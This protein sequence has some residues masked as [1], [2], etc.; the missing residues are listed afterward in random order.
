MGASAALDGRQ[1][2][3]NGSP[4]ILRSCG[5]HGCHGVTNVLPSGADHGDSW[6]PW[7]CLFTARVACAA[8]S[9]RAGEAPVVAPA[10]SPVAQRW[11]DWSVDGWLRW[12]DCQGHGGCSLMRPVALVTGM[13]GVVGAGALPLLTGS[14]E[15]VALTGRRFLE[16][17]CEQVAVDLRARRLGLDAGSF[18][19]LAKRADVIVHMAGNVDY[20]ACAQDLHA[21]NEGGAAE[22][23]ALADAA[24]CPLLY[25]STAFADRHAQA[26]REAGIGGLTP[27]RPS[28]YHRSKAA[29]D[30]RVRQCAQP[31][32]IIRPSIV[33][34]DSR[35]GSMPQRQTMH[36]TL[37]M[38]SSGLL[39][40]MFGHPDHLIDM[41]PRDY[42]AQA[43]HQLA[44]DAVEGRPLPREFWA[45]AGPASLTWAQ[46]SQVLQH[47]LAA[48][49]RP[50][51]PPLQLDP[52]TLDVSDYPGWD[53]LR[54]AHQRGMATLYVASLA[55]GPEAFPTSFAGGGP[56]RP[57]F[58]SALAHCLLAGDIA[59]LLRRSRPHAPTA[60]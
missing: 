12:R 30:E 31:W 32:S 37:S 38:M 59:W 25:V 41:V 52:F 21:V 44:L 56:G 2:R 5:D 11:W 34:G 7:A 60:R 47:T 33:M 4:C 26:S 28:F 50:I 18:A 15:V 27:A 40:A 22:M 20:T 57:A 58:D 35:D 29:A 17:G 49:G 16:A 6:L 45:T 8:W 39:P 3:R 19:L 36:Q 9:A 51:T 43:I 24:E 55:L 54:R 46:W 53:G 14:F 1:P 48:A 42:V 23:A 13:S 10:G